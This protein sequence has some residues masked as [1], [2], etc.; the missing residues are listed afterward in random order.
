V[1]KTLSLTHPILFVMDFHNSETTVPEYSS[2]SLVSASSSCVSVRVVGEVDG[3]V[4][5]LLANEQDLAALPD[6]HDV[7]EGKIATPSR[8]LAVVTAE[9]ESVLQIDVPQERTA[10]RLR[11][12]DTAHPGFVYI[13]IRT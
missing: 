11:V 1:K 5:V 3:E 9:N 13:G 12:D 7:F 4:T 6:L 10:I 2:E 8:Q